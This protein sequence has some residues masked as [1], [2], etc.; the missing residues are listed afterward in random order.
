MTAAS[1]APLLETGLP[2]VARLLAQGLRRIDHPAAR[3]AA[4]SLDRLEQAA[5]C[6][7]LAAERLAEARGLFGGLAG[8]EAV[9]S[10]E[11]DMRPDP[12]SPPAEARADDA[13]PDDAPRDDAYVRRMRPTFGYVLALTWAAQMGAIAYVIV[14]DPRAAPAV[15]ADMANLGMIWT[16]GLSVLGL[17]VYQRSCEKRSG[18]AEALTRPTIAAAPAPVPAV[19]APATA[20]P[21]PVSATPPR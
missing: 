2:L 17:Y 15:I 12:P 5:G 1:P 11:P 21:P 10:A 18:P 13:P 6:G 9:D 14:A 19:P 16:M 4:E 8:P 7:D 3:S 20:A